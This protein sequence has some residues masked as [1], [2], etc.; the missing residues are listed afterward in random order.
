[1]R[2]LFILFGLLLAVRP[3]LAAPSYQF[4]IVNPASPSR[5]HVVWEPLR[6]HL[7]RKLEADIELVFPKGIDAVE[8]LLDQGDI[9]F[10]YMNSYLFYLL[11]N[12]GKLAAVAQM[13]NIEGEVTSQGRFIVRA[14]SG[15]DS[16]QE[17]RGHKLAL[18]SPLGAGAYLAPRAYLSNIGMDIHTDIDLVF[19]GD[20][21]KS[22]YAVLLGDAAATTMCGVNYQILEHKL[23]IKELVILD[24]T[25]PFPEPL[26]AAST[27]LDAS[28][29]ERWREALLNLSTSAA[30]REALRPLADI[31][32]RDFVV[33]D[34]DI[35]TLTRNMMQYSPIP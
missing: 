19:T 21:K 11:Q 29:I 8:K 23:N 32:I 24:S 34:P 28:G 20:L 6:Q 9:D 1:M 22:V 33:Y 27:R 14:D 25:R 7:A 4:A 31:K 10:V 5:L 18:I 13:R 15:I 2:Y 30:G 35:E 3:A 26:V 12:K 17:L 16:V